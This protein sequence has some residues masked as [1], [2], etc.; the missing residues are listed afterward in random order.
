MLYFYY[1]MFFLVGTMAGVITLIFFMGPLARKIGYGHMFSKFVAMFPRLDRSF[2][3]KI[4]K[5]N[6]KGRTLLKKLGIFT[7]NPKK[8][9][10]GGGKSRI[11]IFPEGAGTNFTAEDAAL[12]E[13][14]AKG[15]KNPKIKITETENV[16]FTDLISS[17]KSIMGADALA[18][19]LMTARGAWSPVEP[20]K[21]KISTIKLAGIGVIL[22]VVFVGLYIANTMGLFS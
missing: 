17:V 4:L 20:D 16:S 21:G 19:I 6:I 14:H 3:V 10:I 5:R 7:I 13:R 11:G 18:D 22:L 8:V 12:A 9:Y 1:L 2:E 15:E